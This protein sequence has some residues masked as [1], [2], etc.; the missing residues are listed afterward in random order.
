MWQDIFTAIS[1]YLILEGMI[2]FINP[3][4]F[5]S[6]VTRMSGFSDNNL[7]MIGLISMI[8]GLVLLFFVRG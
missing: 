1:L 5:R 6:F 7:R 8:I 2:P 3:N 4:G